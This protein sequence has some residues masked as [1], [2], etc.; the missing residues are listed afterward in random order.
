V[1]NKKSRRSLKL[2]GMRRLLRETCGPGRR[3]KWSFYSLQ[4][5]NTLA[6]QTLGGV[7]VEIVHAAG[8]EGRAVV[9]LPSK[10]V[11]YYRECG[12]VS[13]IGILLILILGRA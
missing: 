6:R 2:G 4:E 1:L 13:K 3:V 10:Y 8:S 5:K 7:E 12:I 11:T 9:F